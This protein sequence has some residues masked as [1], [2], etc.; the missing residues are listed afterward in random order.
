MVLDKKASQPAEQRSIAIRLSK[1]DVLFIAVVTLLLLIVTSTPTVWA[2]VTPPPDKWF[3]GVVDNVHDTAQY[4]SWMRESATR[5]F[6]DNRLTAEPNPPVFLNLHWW[7]V[8]R[9]AA[10]AGISID[11][12]YQVFR[13][14]SVV[15]LVLMNYAWCAWVFTSL[16]RRRFAFLFSSLAAGLGW[17]WVALKPFTG[18]L[19]FPRDVHNTLG[20]SFYTMVSSPGLTV[21]A[22]LTLLTL[23][24][25]LRGLAQRKL[26]V[27]IVA[28]LL[29]L[30]LGA[31][32]PYDLVT[33]WGVL[34]VTALLFLLRDGFSW[35]TVSCATVVVLVSAPAAAYWA[36]ISSSA[37]PTWQQ[38]LAQYDNLGIFTPDPLHLIVY[39]GL[40]LVLGFIGLKG[41]LPLR[42]QSH[43]QLAV[44]AWFC[45]TLVL[46]Y[47]PFKFQV[48]LLTGYH[49]PLAIMTTYALFDH[50]MPWL[51][52]RLSSARSQ[53][54]VRWLPALVILAVLP[55]NVYLFGWRMIDLSRYKLPYYLSRDDVAAMAWLS[56]RDAENAV[57]MSAFTTGQYLPGFTGQRAFL[58]NA[59]M[60]LDFYRKYD[61]SSAFYSPQ[62]PDV[63]RARVI[64]DYGI[65]Y[66]Y[67]GDAERELGAYNFDRSA[68][69]S[70]VF[71]TG[72]VTIYETRR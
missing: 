32:H 27:C 6:I 36:W 7:L 20:N 37:N 53:N 24:V 30:F 50:I 23:M 55:S 22:A 64:R 8:G 39:L 12:A 43:L 71:K 48:T 65:R 33:V 41:T 25:A 44:K 18:D 62:S 66:V 14:L 9:F 13:V 67:V 15:F 35:R 21:S 63:N 38:A 72:D 2:Y 10:V 58:S 61:L 69:F 56:D 34:G 68:L 70:P 28:G 45:T 42:G 49:V 52:A 57:V 59:V 54:W 60:T 47:L 40:P 11:A 17:I 46:I 26:G 3:S 5:L 29:S 4:W 51:S 19:L 31:G 1:S 16:A